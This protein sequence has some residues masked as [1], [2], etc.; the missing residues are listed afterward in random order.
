MLWLIHSVTKILAIL[1]GSL[2]LRRFP[3]FC[4]ALVG[5]Y[6]FLQIPLRLLYGYLCVIVE[7]K[8]PR[9]RRWYR[10]RL[11]VP[12]FVAALLSAWFSLQLLNRNKPSRVNEATTT[13]RLETPRQDGSDAAVE[14]TT[15]TRL[16]PG[17]IEA[18][19]L[20]AGK[21]LDL[22]ILVA[23]RALDTLITNL[24]RRSHAHYLPTTTTKAISNHA[25]NLLF[26]LSSGT[27]MWTWVYH[28]P[29]PAPPT[30]NH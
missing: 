25:S 22:T 21:T 18:P 20:L 4:G 28:P 13:R 7:G 17:D 8:S 15:T 29:P 9:L 3:T 10:G 16:T 27:I 2:A 12:R 23:S 11:A 30:K 19:I 6:T 5:G 1:K 26:A 24:W 14:A